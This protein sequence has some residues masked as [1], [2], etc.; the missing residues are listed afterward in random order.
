MTTDHPTSQRVLVT[1]A[2]GF[3]GGAVMR[4]LRSRGFGPERA[5]GVGSRDADLT[6]RLG[7]RRVLRETFNAQGPTGVIHCAGAVGGLQ[8]N[9]DSPATFF[10]HN[11]AMA[12]NLIE[13]FRLAGMIERGAAFVQIGSMTSYPAHAPVPF[14]EDSLWSGYPDPASAPYA[15]AKLAAW[16]MLDS[17][18]KQYGMNAAYLIPVNLYGPGDRVNDERRAHVAGTLVKRFVDAARAGASDVV[19]W[20]DGSPTRDFL[21]VDDAAEA[22]VAA[23]AR[24]GSPRPINLGSGIEVSIR[25]LAQSIAA[26]AGFQGI[27]RWDTSKPGG[28]ARRCMD[29]SRANDVLAWHPRTSLEDGLRQTIDW[30]RST[31]AT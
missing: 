24:A 29:I 21:Y 15:I 18:A 26:L 3:L 11:A 25:S 12:L 10:F 13:E 27:I 1:G 9:L 17:Y 23:L 7:A 31:L 6:T 2:T 5:V 8:A 14:C 4:L 16:Q 22:A 30:Y 19:C 28:Q 20:G